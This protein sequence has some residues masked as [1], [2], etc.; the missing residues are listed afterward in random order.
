MSEQKENITPFQV[1]VMA[2]IQVIGTSLAVLDPTKREAVN[3]AIVRL[4]DSIP[5]DK[6][7]ADGSS[8]GHL[9]LKALQKG[10]RLDLK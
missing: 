10:L 1:G 8:Q 6:S 7:L 9:A 2:A 3:D 4:L 5:E